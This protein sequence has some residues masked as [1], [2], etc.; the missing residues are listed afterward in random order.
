MLKRIPGWNTY[1]STANESD[2]TESIRQH[3]RTGRPFGSAEFIQ[4]L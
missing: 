3:N 2:R 1:L 4:T